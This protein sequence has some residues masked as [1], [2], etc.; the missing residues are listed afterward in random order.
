[1]SPDYLDFLNDL[2][3]FKIKLG[4]Q[5]I[6]NLLGRL[7]HPQHHPRI[8]HIAGTNGKGSTLV[9]LESLLIESGYST[10]SF[11]SPCL[12]EFNEYFR[13]NGKT[14]GDDEIE[15]AFQE[16]CSVCGIHPKEKDNPTK[17]A[18]LIP[19]HFEFVFAISLL[20]F[21]KAK[22]DFVLLE[23][24][25][26]GLTDATNVIEH[27]LATVLTHISYDH[28]EFLGE[29]LEEITRQKLGIV[30]KGSPLFVAQQSE[31]VSKIIQQALNEQDLQV[32]RNPND[33][34]ITENP[35]GMVFQFKE[36]AVPDAVLLRSKGLTG[37]HQW[38]NIS[39]ALAMYFS[40]ADH[41]NRLNPDQINECI[42]KVSW[43]GRLQYVKN[44]KVLL[45]GAHNQSAM[46]VLFDY[47]RKYHREQRILM[48]IGW[49]DNKNP[50][51]EQ[52]MRDISNITFQPILF[53]F[54]AAES[55]DKKRDALFNIS[56]KIRP[57]QI[58]SQYFNA[59]F[60]ND[61]ADFDLIVVSGS[62]HLIGEYSRFQ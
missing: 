49:L 27:P 8:I 52:T 45:D 1:M 38:E 40:V 57:F 47:L 20:L 22:V 6:Q 39:T 24:G 15:S 12:H 53:R 2:G 5:N 7:N 41:S 10:G 33:F 9:T 30:K 62:L 46:G 34:N 13:I 23:T 19:T 17:K 25:L 28:Q 42:G 29:T 21:R 26:G 16:I 35:D 44:G 43:P 31:T 51:S 4:L 11:I 55:A 18:D 32:Y 59:E 48:V 54:N 61:L 56:D 14:P 60:Q 58:S 3:L 37:D 50:I 36:S